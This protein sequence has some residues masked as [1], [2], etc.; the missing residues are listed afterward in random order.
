MDATTHFITNIDLRFRAIANRNARK[1]HTFYYAYVCRA[2]ER[3]KVAEYSGCRF[4][5]LTIIPNDFRGATET[6]EELVCNA[7]T[8]AINVAPRKSSSPYLNR[9]ESS[10]VLQKKEN[11]RQNGVFASTKHLLISDS[12]SIIGAQLRDKLRNLERKEIVNFSSLV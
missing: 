11:K 10:V 4:I 7:R 8:A 3:I 12:C 1:D 5:G 9:R 2:R 6:T